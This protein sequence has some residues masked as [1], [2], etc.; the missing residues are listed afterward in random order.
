M[1]IILNQVAIWRPCRAK[2][3]N[4]RKS[5]AGRQ[6]REPNAVV[7]KNSTGPLIRYAKD[8]TIKKVGFSLFVHTDC[9]DAAKVESALDN[10]ATQVTKDYALQA[11]ANATAA[12]FEY[13]PFILDTKQIIAKE[14]K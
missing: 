13:T 8:Y 9:E 14:N 2:K 1:D 6:Y 5:P 3:L 4:I 11:T 10:F 12:V 7:Y